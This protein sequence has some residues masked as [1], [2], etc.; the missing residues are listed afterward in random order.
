[1]SAA[2]SLSWVLA[3]EHRESRINKHHHPKKTANLH[4]YGLFPKGPLDGYQTK[5]TS[6]TPWQNI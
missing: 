4:N 2:R 6:T 1:M 3:L 5:N